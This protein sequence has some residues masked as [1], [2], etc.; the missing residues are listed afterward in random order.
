MIA[1]TL[2]T[3]YKINNGSKPEQTY[4]EAFIYHM[5]S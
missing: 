1:E 2:I 3:N 5:I 4:E